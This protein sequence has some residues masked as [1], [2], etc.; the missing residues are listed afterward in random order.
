M[1]RPKLEVYVSDGCSIC[2]RAVRALQ[3]CEQI[4][5]VAD[6]AVCNLDA[7]DVARPPQL[8]A[9]PTVYYEGVVMALGT[10]DCCELAS[11]LAT[12]MAAAG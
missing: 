10:P 8:V 7:P 1:K 4:A 3:D 11:R 2:S 9:V 12:A 6:V 5:A